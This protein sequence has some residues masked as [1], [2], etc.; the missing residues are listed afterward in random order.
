A[1]MAE[2]IAAVTGWK[3]SMVELERIAERIFTMARL[4][5]IREGFTSEDDNLPPRFFQPKIDGSLFGRA[6]DP[7]KMEKAK[8]YYYMIMG[9]NEKG[10]PLS[11]KIQE[12]DIQ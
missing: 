2:I 4:F 9:W 7:D 3:I 11:E 12:L 1:T 6:L 10:I 8:R 5:N